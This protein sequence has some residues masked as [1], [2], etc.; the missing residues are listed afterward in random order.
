M[1]IRALLRTLAVHLSHPVTSLQHPVTTL[2]ARLV[3]MIKKKSRR[4]KG[5]FYSS[6]QA[7]SAECL[8]TIVEEGSNGVAPLF[9][10]GN[11]RISSVV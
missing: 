9:E 6:K 5:S 3:D 7:R 1:Q 11:S 4:K 2:L 10:N 8:L